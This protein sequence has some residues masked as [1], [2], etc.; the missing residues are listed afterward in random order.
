MLML[1][2]ASVTGC[3][4]N[5]KGPHACSETPGNACV[6]AGKSGVEGFNGDGL[7]RRDTEL[8]WTMDVSF[9]ADGTVWF[10]DWNNHLVRRVLEDD[11]VTTMVG[12][13]DP[14]F[15]G[16]GLPGPSEKSADGALGTDVKLNHPTDLVQE[17][18]GKVLV[19]A[20]HNHKLREVD[21][22]TGHV[23]I[24]AGG[25]AGFAGD[26]MPMAMALF[27]QP[28]ALERDAAGNLYILDQQ[29]FRI[30]KIDTSGVVST[31]AGSGMQGS[32]GDGGP[33][34]MAKLDFEAGSNPEPSGG[35]VVTHDK[36]YV[37]DTLANK[38]RAIDLTT[39]MITTIAGTGAEGGGGDG[40]PAMAAQLAHPRDLEIGPEGDLYVADTDNNRI[41]AINLTTGVIRTVAGT[42]ELGLDKDDDH[43]ATQMKLARPFGIEFDPDGNL[44]ISDTINSRILKVF[45]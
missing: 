40:G 20:W 8:Y 43:P 24:L 9:A 42:G 16:D 34:L 7:D 44:F 10:I 15:P 33:A 27:K 2:A 5:L 1:A 18:N 11:T 36:L 14:V 32:D 35:M 39:Q 17:P 31:I 21:P 13:T 6:Y 38:L 29:N 25:G 4:D 3:G 28:K 12:W 45:R 22:V 19:M 41:R 30:R 37:S 23:R 26:G